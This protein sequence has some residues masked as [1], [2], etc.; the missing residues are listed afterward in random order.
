MSLSIRLRKCGGHGLEK[1]VTEGVVW[2]ALRVSE[3]K[4]SNVR[5][6]LNP[7]VVG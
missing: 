3:L 4:V 5:K 7:T 6:I 2:N 1:G